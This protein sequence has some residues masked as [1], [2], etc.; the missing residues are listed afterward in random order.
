ML[1]GTRAHY[2]AGS[3]VSHCSV[4]AS[5]PATSTSQIFV[6]GGQALNQTAR[7][8]ALY[9]L[10]L[11]SFTWTQISSST[12]P[13]PSEPTG[14]AGHQC[15]LDGSQLV[16]I[17]GYVSEALLCDQPGIYVYDVSKGGW[18]TAFTAGTAYT[19]PALISSAAGSPSGSSPNVGA[20]AGGVVGGLLALL[21]I[22]GLLLLSRRRKRAAQAQ[23]GFSV[24]SRRSSGPART[25]SGEGSNEDE[26][27]GCVPS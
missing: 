16:S 14:R 26:K 23:L 25:D 7:D 22:L 24:T 20:I 19:V 2:S 6:Y 12:S 18:Q 8:S 21:L 3:R 17:G 5:D 13:L 15:I 11:P 1:V 27:R 4:L 9:I 10:S